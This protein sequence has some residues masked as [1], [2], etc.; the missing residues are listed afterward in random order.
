VIRDRNHGGS[1][2]EADS[3]KSLTILCG[4]PINP[5]DMIFYYHEAF[6]ATANR[7]KICYSG[8]DQS[9]L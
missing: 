8:G 2:S 1:D 6:G 7:R 5:G 4:E 9:R 3:G